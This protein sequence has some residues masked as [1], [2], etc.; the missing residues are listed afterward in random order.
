VERQET[1]DRLGYSRYDK[2]DLRWCT[3]HPSEMA[4]KQYRYDIG[5]YDCKDNTWTRE[6]TRHATHKF[7]A[8][9]QTGR[10]SPTRPAETCNR[11]LGRDRQW[12]R[13][14]EAMYGFNHHTLNQLGSEGV[15]LI[16]QEMRGAPSPAASTGNISSASSTPK[17]QRISPTRAHLV[18]P[19]ST[20]AVTDNGNASLEEA[21]KPDLSR[22]KPSEVLDKTG[23]EDLEQLLSFAAIVSG[24][25]RSILCAT[26]STK[27]SFVE[28]WMLYSEW[29]YGHKRNH[30]KDLAKDYGVSKNTAWKVLQAKL[31]FVLRAR[32][33]WPNY[34]TNEEDVKFRKPTWRE[35]F[36]DSTRVVMHDNTNVPLVDPSDPDIY[37]SLRSEYYAMC[38]AKGGIALQLCGWIRAT[39]LMTGAVGDSE[40][41]KIV[42][43]L[44]E[45]KAFAEWDQSTL[46]SFLNIFDKGYRCTLDALQEGQKCLQP[47]FAR[48]DEQFTRE[49]TLYS[50]AVAVIRSSNERAVKMMKLSWKNRNGVNGARASLKTVADIWLAWGFQINFMYSP[51]L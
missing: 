21:L 15:E 6:K 24:G 14:S 42:N 27:L 2:R 38:C 44:Q 20:P 39:E 26:Q 35:H 30:L 13:T 11:G 46:E 22:W 18:S 33:G 37:R 40:Y 47:T 8:P 43:L 3:D 31:I 4:S 7:M 12:T 28:E 10:Q 5:T 29:I 32:A 51:V 34:A 49:E 48:S 1:L 50:A 36:S 25:K 23:F 9:V 16:I 19:L 17:R 41:V 45:Q